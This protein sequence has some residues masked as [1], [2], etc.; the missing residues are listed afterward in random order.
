MMMRDFDIKRLPVIKDKKFVGLLTLKDILKIE[1]QLFDM[2]VDRIELREEPSKPIR[3]ITDNE[4]ICSIC[5]T[6]DQSLTKNPDGVFV[7]NT[8]LD[9]Q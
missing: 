1:P 9:E 2:L 7:C 5:G 8:C 6:F 3:K 4:G